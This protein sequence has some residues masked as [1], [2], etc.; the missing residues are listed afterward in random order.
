MRS[1]PWTLLTCVALAAGCEP[2][3]KPFRPLPASFEVTTLTGEKLSAAEL[4]GRP[5]VI[6]LWVPG[7]GSC[8]RE[9][10]DLE[11]VRHEFE[12]QGVGFLAVSLEPDTGLVMSAVRRL[13]L[14]I[15]VATTRGETLGPLNVNQ[16]PSTVFVNSE[17]IIVAAASGARKRSFFEARVEALVD[18]HQ[19]R[20]D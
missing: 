3:E 14:G 5:W 10:P 6:N 11:S 4:K 18:S 19:A 20:A 7:C 1:A 8:V 15:T 9:F 2:Y 17:G 16:V 13:E 12:P